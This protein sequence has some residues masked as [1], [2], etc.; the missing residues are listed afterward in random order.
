MGVFT[1]IVLGLLAIVV[2][3]AIVG[4]FLP[5]HA[6]VERS[7]VIEAPQA[8][9]FAQVNGFHSFNQWSPWFAKDPGCKYVYEGPRQGVGSKLHWVGDPKTVGSG[10]QEIIESRPLDLVRIQLDFA[11]Q[12]VAVAHFTLA[13]EGKGTRVTWG[14]DSDLGMSPLSRYFGLLFDRMIGPD[15]EKG[16]AG[17]KTLAEG[18]PKTDFAGLEV[19]EVTVEPVTVAYLATTCA[20]DEASIASA[21][22][23]A[24]GQIGKFMKAH[25]LGMA[26]API[27]INT[28]WSDERYEFDAAIPVNREPAQEVPADS[29]VKVKKTYGGRALK[30]VHRGA[31]RTMDETYDRLLAYAAAHG[32][33][34]AGPPWDEYVTDPGNTPEADLRTHILMPVK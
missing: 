13:P 30:V 20:T 27:T 19:E 9:V 23:A 8:T 6:Q 21:I 10:S 14:F 3:L 28:S 33:E 34:K 29:P 25:G 24:Y 22:G 1:K 31:Y 7:I 32:Y 18:L 5:R 16:L 11:G 26:G 15:Y 17:L 4:F 12:G 2:L